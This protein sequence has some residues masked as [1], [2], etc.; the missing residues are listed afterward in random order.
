MNDDEVRK[1]MTGID[2]RRENISFCFEGGECFV[3]IA[4]YQNLI[5]IKRCLPFT[6]DPDLPLA[7]G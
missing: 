7:H 2:V 1:I 6:Y 4:P 5:V 3:T